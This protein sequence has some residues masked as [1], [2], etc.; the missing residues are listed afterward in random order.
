MLK[1]NLEEKD[2]KEIEQESGN[3]ASSYVF[4]DSDDEGK[5]SGKKL[6]ESGSTSDPKKRVKKLDE[7]KKVKKY[8]LAVREHRRAIKE[9]QIIVNQLTKDVEKNENRNSTSKKSNSS[10]WRNF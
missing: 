5:R 6:K 2:P 8:R 10:S 9:L 7:R 4:K 1:E 3:D